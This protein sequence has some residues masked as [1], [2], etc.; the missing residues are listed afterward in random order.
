MSHLKASGNDRN[1]NKA[2]TEIARL[3]TA[4]RL[5]VRLSRYF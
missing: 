1:R 5:S 2:R 3:V 4:V